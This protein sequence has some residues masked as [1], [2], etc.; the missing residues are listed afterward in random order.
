MTALKTGRTTFQIRGKVHDFIGEFTEEEIIVQIRRG[1]LDGEDEFSVPPHQKWKKITSHPAFFDALVGR[2]LNLPQKDLPSE[3]DVLNAFTENSID[4]QKRVLD[5]EG[6][7]HLDQGSAVNDLDFPQDH[8]GVTEQIHN[9]EHPFPDSE[10]EALFRD[11]PSEIV[12]ITTDPTPPRE[13]LDPPPAPVEA[14]ETKSRP[15]RK[16]MILWAAVALVLIVLFQNGKETQPVVKESKPQAVALPAANT[17]DEASYFRKSGA[18]AFEMDSPKGYAAASQF[19]IK[20]VEL[21]PTDLGLLDSL[22]LSLARVVEEN[23]KDQKARVLLEKYL[24]EGRRLDPH[25]SVF[26]RAEAMM[27]RALEGPQ[28]G[29]ELLDLALQ[30]DSLNPGNLLIQA[31]Q[32]ILNQQYSEAKKLLSAVSEW[33]EQKAR[34][35][36]LIALSAFHLGDYET[37]W[38]AVQKVI[39]LNPTHVPSYSLLGDLFTARNDLKGAKAFYELGAK[40]AQLA[41]VEIAAHSLIRA[42]EL[43][44]LGSDSQLARQYYV[45]AS[46]LVGPE[47]GRV[48]EKLSGEKPSE[49]EIKAATS[50][51]L[52]DPAYFERKGVEASEEKNYERAE[53][54]YQSASWLFPQLGKFLYRLGEVREALAKTKE[55]FRWAATT[56]R[57]AIQVSPEQ[58]DAYLKLALLETEQSNF[59]VAFDLLQRAEQLS[60]EDGAVQLAL[61]KHLFARKDYRAAIERLRTARR[62]NPGNSEVSYYQ[63]LLYKMFDPSNPKAAMR[64]FEEAYSK[65]P[66]N[67]DALVEWLKLKVATFEKMFAVKFLR[68]M[69]ATDPKNPNLLWVSGE[70]F[71]ANQEF[72][73]AVQ[74]YHRALDIDKYASKVRLSLARSLVSL[75]K[76]DEAVAEYKLAADLDAKNGEGYFYAAELLYQMKNYDGCRDLVLGLLQ[77]I[78]SY[79][80]ARRLLA[81]S[82]QASEKKDLAIDEM[83][84]EVQANPLNYQFLIEYA[85]LL[86]INEKYVEATNQLGKVAQLPLEQTVKDQRAPNGVRTEPTGY[87]NYRLKALLLL[88]RSYRKLSRYEQAEGLVNSALAI[89]PE[90]VDLRLERGYVLNSLGRHRDAAVDF[91]FFLGKN[92][93]APEAEEVKQIL[94]STLIEE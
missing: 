63:G 3:S 21:K 50:Q 67:Y 65:D 25:R 2:A 59:D 94:K 33:D 83:S 20:A 38:A 29:Q 42:G 32:L 51:V 57:Q 7:H 31:E 17:S 6:T 13:E 55:E 9:P 76:L 12:P 58:I 39:Q 4:P 92:P 82:Y 78:P 46:Q 66:S 79:P 53:G 84:K 61:G 1:K 10:I 19:F 71:A 8:L 37:T 81:M 86:M 68:N 90:N 14:S 77:L 72:N 23:P 18:R 16:R 89:D 26:Y 73:R 91:N 24:K 47:I 30:T 93:N 15:N 60:P 70:V 56:Y 5:G 62:A 35:S 52:A 11:E 85:E 49:D 54:F 40:L 88:S 80:G 64:H 74:N 43:S 41:P 45:T 69:L 75:G 27:A 36:Y 48:K 44:E 87:K 22:T 34:V 28:K